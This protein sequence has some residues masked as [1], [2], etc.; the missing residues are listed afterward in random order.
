MAKAIEAPFTV[1]AEV[2][3]DGPRIEAWDGN[4]VC[5][6]PIASGNYRIRYCARNMDKAKDVD[7]LLENEDT[8]DFYAL[9]VWPDE[10]ALDEIS[11]FSRR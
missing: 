9:Y 11:D 7:T 8:I 1:G 10:V 6:L 2:D 3:K 4:L 5:N